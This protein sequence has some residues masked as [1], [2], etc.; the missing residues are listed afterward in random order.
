M[1]YLLYILILFITIRT[2][3]ST[4]NLIW[5]RF[6]V[7]KEIQNCS[8]INIEY[9]LLIPA[10]DEEKNINNILNDITQFK[11]K[12]QE[13]II[14][15]D[16]S[17]DKTKEIIES[18]YNSIQNLRVIDNL[19]PAPPNG[20]LGK[21]WGC[22]NLAQNTTTEYLL[23]CDADVRLKSDF[24]KYIL[25]AK[26]N[27]AQLLSLFPYQITTGF[28]VKLVIPI[29]N[30]ILITLLPLFF[31]KKCSWSSF[32]AANGQFMLFLKESYKEIE[33]H[34]I[35]KSSRAEDIEICRLYKK[36]KKRCITLISNKSVQCKMYSSFKESINGFS[37]NIVQFFGG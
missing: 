17:T 27:S 30:W 4:L 12:P 34:Q 28:G 3:V 1:E 21:N 7:E 9:S 6:I 31:V 18:Y 15:N 26:S 19:Y 16:N 23:F 10:R 32:S 14:F 37:K 20:W 29:M 13:V 2:I 24:Y 8:N 11:I 25:Y 22:Y 5:L 35:L 33:P 36:R